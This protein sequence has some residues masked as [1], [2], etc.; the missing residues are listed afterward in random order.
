MFPTSKNTPSGSKSTMT[1]N[2]T[3][4]KLMASRT[5]SIARTVRCLGMLTKAFGII[6][7]LFDT[8]CRWQVDRNRFDIEKKLRTTGK[9]LRRA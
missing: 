6:L 5:I 8:H 3:I 7:Y 9:Y 1:T 4:W 2:D